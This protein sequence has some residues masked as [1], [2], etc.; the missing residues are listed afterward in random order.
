MPRWNDPAWQNAW[1][2]VLPYLSRDD[3]VLVP[4]AHWPSTEVAEM[5]AYRYVIDI[6]DATVLFLYKGRMS[7]ISPPL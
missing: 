7:G 2:A 5:R 1:Q 6:G 3:R 4:D